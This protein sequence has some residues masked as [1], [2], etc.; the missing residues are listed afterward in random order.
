MTRTLAE[1]NTR[2]ASET[3]YTFELL[4]DGQKTGVMLDV[5]GQQSE[6][7]TSK[8]TAIA[9]EYELAKGLETDP[10]A[11][12]VSDR[13]RLMTNKLVAARLVGWAGIKEDF[14]DEAAIEL[15]ASNQDAFSQIVEAS[16]K[17][18]NFIKL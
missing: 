12:L 14:S 16:N 18:G 10:S 9:K 13:T 3:P 2:K 17:I 1:L 8:A 7:F 11:F 4:I 5:V 6:T 15:V